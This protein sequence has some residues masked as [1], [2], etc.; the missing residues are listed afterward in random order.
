M[1]PDG[2]T[3]YVQVIYTQTFA[4]VP[5]QGASAASGSIGLGTITK[6]KTSGAAEKK[7][8]VGGVWTAAVVA[9]MGAVGAGFW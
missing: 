8:V 4:S 7:V 3:T 2:V 6:N 5:S 1:L 9:I